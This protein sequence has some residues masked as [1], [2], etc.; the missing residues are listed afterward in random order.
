MKKLLMVT[1]LALM[2]LGGSVIAA[3]VDINSANAEQ[4]AENLKGIGVN[5]AQAIVDYRTQNGPFKHPDELVN[6]KGIGLK[7]VEKNMPNIQLGKT[8]NKKRS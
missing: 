5:K 8:A 3:P 1:T 2:L 4:I 6:V 7:T